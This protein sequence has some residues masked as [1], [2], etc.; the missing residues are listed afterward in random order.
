VVFDCAFGNV[1]PEFPPVAPLIAG[2]GNQLHDF[3]QSLAGLRRKCARSKLCN[4]MSNFPLLPM[5]TIMFCEDFHRGLTAIR[6]RRP[7]ILR[8]GHHDI[9][10]QMV[11]LDLESS[12]DLRHESMR[13]QTKASGKKASKTTNSPSGSGT[14]SAPGTRPTPL[15]KYPSC[16]ISCTWTEEIRDMP[17]S[18]VSPG[19]NSSAATLLSVSSDDAPTGGVSAAEEEEDGMATYRRRRRAVCFTRARSPINRSKEGKRAIKRFQEEARV[20]RRAERV[21]DPRRPAPFLY[22]GR[23]AL[24]NP[25]SNSAASVN[26]HIKTPRGTTSSEG[27]V[28]TI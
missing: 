12:Q 4:L 27:S 15:P 7:D 24:G 16:C 21:P 19:C 26:G 1:K 8:Q 10:R 18:T 20:S 3:H 17:N 2:A 13:R 9:R 22:T 14:S 25:Q 11:D 5:Q 6:S 28:S 23:D